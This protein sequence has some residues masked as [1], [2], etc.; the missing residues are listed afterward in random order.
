MDVFNY[1][2]KTVSEDLNVS[3]CP[4]KYMSRKLGKFKG[5]PTK[6]DTTFVLKLPILKRTRTSTGKTG[7]AR[8]SLLL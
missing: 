5:S 6:P 8:F 3:T 7:H 2:S 4:P 1:K